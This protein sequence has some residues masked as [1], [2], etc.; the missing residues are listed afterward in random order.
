M[1][2]LLLSPTASASAPAAFA[3][4]PVVAAD[5]CLPVA[6]TAADGIRICPC[7]CRHLLP[8]FL[9]TLAYLLLLLPLLLMASTSA[10]VA[11]RIC[12]RRSS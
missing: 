10:P 9:L 8:L 5:T 2:L 6:A 4:A 12:S 7:C 1:Y 3:S 11:A